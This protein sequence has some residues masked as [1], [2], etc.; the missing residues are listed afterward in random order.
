MDFNSKNVLGMTKEHSMKLLTPKAAA[1]KTGI[2]QAG[3]RWNEARGRLLC[4]KVDC[5]T[6]RYQRLYLEDELDRFLRARAKPPEVAEVV[7]V[8]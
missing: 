2:T 8:A 5:G 1:I 6:G 7:E 3:L 4:I